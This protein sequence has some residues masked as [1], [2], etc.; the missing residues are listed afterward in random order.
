M[1]TFKQLRQS[2][3]ESFED[4]RGIVKYTKDW[5]EDVLAD[6]SAVDDYIPKVKVEFD[7]SG[8]NI[9][10]NISGDV[11]GKI[12][13]PVYVNGKREDDEI[14]RDILDIKKELSNELTDLIKTKKKK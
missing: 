3:Q 10:L 14:K 11:N 4:Y 13:I 12:S 7:Q 9:D 5:L 2:L 8:M 6:E 1:K